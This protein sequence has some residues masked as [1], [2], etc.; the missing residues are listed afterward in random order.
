[1]IELSEV[2]RDLRSELEAAVDS[3]PADGLRF[4]LGPIDLEVSVGLDRSAGASA[5]IRFWV[6][7][8]GPEGSVAQSSTQRVKLTLQ[9]RMGGS[10]HSP[11]VS[12]PQA[13]QER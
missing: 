6:V 1:M 3:A 7:D 4:E 2:I 8:L 11:Y 10:G 13:P 12:G 9:P 5:K